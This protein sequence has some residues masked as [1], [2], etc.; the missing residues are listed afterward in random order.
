ML[1]HL[2]LQSSLFLAASFKN[3]KLLLSLE[4]LFAC[5]KKKKKKNISEQDETAILFLHEKIISLI[6]VVNKNI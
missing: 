1:S 4:I 5:D 6:L 2:C 3:R